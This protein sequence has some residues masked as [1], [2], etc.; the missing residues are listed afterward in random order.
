MAPKGD[1]MPPKI[2][3]TDPRDNRPLTDREQMLL[4]IEAGNQ[5]AQALAYFQ[6]QQNHGCGLAAFACGF[7]DALIHDEEYHRFSREEI[8]E[9][10]RAALQ[11]R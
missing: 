6:E 10:L 11:G 5:E 8:L 9:L 2:V 1:A 4:Q 7:Y 3:L